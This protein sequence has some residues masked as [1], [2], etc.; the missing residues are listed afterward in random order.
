MSACTL[1][2]FAQ[3]LSAGR[4]YP[5]TLALLDERTHVLGPLCTDIY[6]QLMHNQ[7]EKVPSF[8]Y[9]HLNV[10]KE[11]AR[12]VGLGHKPCP[13]ATVLVCYTRQGGQDIRGHRL[14]LVTRRAAFCVH[15]T[16]LQ[17][18]GEGEMD[19]VC[20]VNT[21]DRWLCYILL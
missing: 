19:G 10:S 18:W 5:L 15:Y 20:G 9:L 6:V 16:H 2:L 8:N 7:R 3:I 17:G 14:T 1:Y 12:K 21:M 11:L 4:F 13:G